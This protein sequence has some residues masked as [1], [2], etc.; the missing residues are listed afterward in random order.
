MTLD[1]ARWQFAIITVYSGRRAAA[2][3]TRGARAR[4]GGRR[5]DTVLV[6]WASGAPTRRV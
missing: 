6:G 3:L 4:A 5:R 1:L 2:H